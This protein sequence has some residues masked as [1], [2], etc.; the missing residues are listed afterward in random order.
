MVRFTRQDI[1]CWADGALGWAHVRSVLADLVEDLAPHVARELRA[2]PSPDYSEEYD[3]LDILQGVT[4]EGLVWVLDS[5]GLFL[6]A[7]E[8]EE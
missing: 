2:E 5:E 1:G 3:A 7:E 8:E 4:E 6:R